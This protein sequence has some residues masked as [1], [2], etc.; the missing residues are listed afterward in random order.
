LVAQC[1]T[2]PLFLQRMSM[3]PHVI[4]AEISGTSTTLNLSPYP[5]IAYILIWQVGST[6]FGYEVGELISLLF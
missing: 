1:K 3:L 2:L 4:F 6:W 5:F